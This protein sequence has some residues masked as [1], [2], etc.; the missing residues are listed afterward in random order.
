MGV[1]T[2]TSLKTSLILDLSLDPSQKPLEGSSTVSHSE[3][4]VMKLR[5][6]VIVERKSDPPI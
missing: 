3:E 2:L 4:F 5:S 6:E 1:D